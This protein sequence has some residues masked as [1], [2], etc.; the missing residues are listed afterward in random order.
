[1]YRALVIL[2]V[3][4]LAGCTSVHQRADGT[5]D[6]PRTVEVRSPFGTNAGFVKLE[7]CLTKVPSSYW[8]DEYTNCHAMKSWAVVQSQGQGGQ[9]VSGALTG[10]GFGLGS[11]FSGAGNAAGA[12]TNSVTNTTTKSVVNGGYR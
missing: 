11:A 4:V 2:G 5:W 1:M 12:V 9:V 6:V 3:V 8:Y 7:H 10:L